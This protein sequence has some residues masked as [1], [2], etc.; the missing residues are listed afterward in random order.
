LALATT[1]AHAEDINTHIGTRSFTHD[2]AN[3]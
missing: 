2:F 3:G 1:G